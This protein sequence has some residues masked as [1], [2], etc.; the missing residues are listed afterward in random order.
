[1]TGKSFR[2]G[3]IMKVKNEKI[4]FFGGKY[5]GFAIWIFR[6]QLVATAQFQKL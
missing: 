4:L 5:R 1:M 6:R 3:T 2:Y